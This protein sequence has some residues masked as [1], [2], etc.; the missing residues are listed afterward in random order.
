MAEWRA[1]QGY[2]EGGWAAMIQHYFLGAIVPKQDQYN[3]YYTKIVDNNRYIVGL[4]TGDF[5]VAAGISRRTE[6]GRKDRL[7]WIPGVRGEVQCPRP[8]SNEDDP[9]FLGAGSFRVHHRQLTVP[10]NEGSLP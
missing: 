9:N 3:N 8:W 4:Q 6:P 1:P 2:T 5:T 7:E 10:T